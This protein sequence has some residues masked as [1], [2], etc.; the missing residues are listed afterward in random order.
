[1]KRQTTQHIVDFEHVQLATVRG[2]IGQ[3]IKDGNITIVA[4]TLTHNGLLYAAL[5]VYE[6][7]E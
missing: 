4:I 2:R 5:V 6:V 7:A 3:F 1:M